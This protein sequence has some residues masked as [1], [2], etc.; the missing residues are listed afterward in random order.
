MEMTDASIRAFLG[1]HRE[2]RD[3]P[4][5]L[6]LANDSVLVVPYEDEWRWLF[7]EWAAQLGEVA[8]RIDHIGSTSVPVIDVQ[9]SVAAL[10][11]ADTFRVPLAVP[12]GYRER[13]EQTQV[14]LSS[15]CN[16]RRRQN[17]V[18]GLGNAK[19]RRV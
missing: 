7:R 13:V 2:G 19:F 10:G 4:P 3:M 17:P 9:I 15:A 16:I 11:P 5:S 14:Q 1:S 12:S 8:L 6:M 18:D